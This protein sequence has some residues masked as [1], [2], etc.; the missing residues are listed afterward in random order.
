MRGARVP[1]GGVHHGLLVPALVV[2]QVIARLQQRLADTGDVAVTEDAEA[3]SKEPAGDAVALA[4]LDGEEAD[5]GLRHR[6]PHGASPA[7]VRGSRASTCWDSQLPRI[8][9][10]AGSSQNAIDRSAAGPA[11]TFR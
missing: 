3:A 9:A 11:S 6:Q 2:P 5:E 7:E 1:G 10:C 4:V 8:H